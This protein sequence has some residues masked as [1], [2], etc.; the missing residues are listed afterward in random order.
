MRVKVSY[1]TDLDQVPYECWRLLDYKVHNGFEFTE[2]LKN[3]YQSLD[4]NADPVSILNDIHEMRM[5]LSSY[6]QCLADIDT[7]LTGFANVR[8]Q[9]HTERDNLHNEQSE[10]KEQMNI[11][12]MLEQ[13]KNLKDKLE[14]A[15]ENV[16]ETSDDEL[17]V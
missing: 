10:P 9:N 14:P 15:T 13:L 7:I 2:K 17:P 3:L 12:N 4:N 1:T 16:E 11:Q 6:D 5:I 8:L